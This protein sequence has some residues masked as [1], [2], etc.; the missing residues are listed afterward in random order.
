MADRSRLSRGRFFRGALALALLA[1]PIGPLH[2]GTARADGNADEAQLH[3]EIAAEHYRTG[4]FRTALEHFLL[5]NRLV[6]NKNVVFNIAR[7]Y[8]QLKRY[9]D[10]HRYYVDALDGETN[11]QTSATIQDAIKRIAPNV[12]VLRVESDPPG[13]IIYLERKDLGARG[14]AP[15]PLAVPEGKYKVIV[16]L[17]GY[18]PVTIDGVT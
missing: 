9:A 2:R 17:D 7:T 11:P 8:E 3:F 12:A 16:E 14:R 1:S 4:D 15:K 18:D 6:A 5:S 10:A 13:A